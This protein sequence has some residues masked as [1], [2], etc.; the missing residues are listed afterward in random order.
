MLTLC[1]VVNSSWHLG[2]AWGSS[3]LK[4]E[5]FI[6]KMEA[7]HWVGNDALWVVTVTVNL[8]ERRCHVER[9]RLLSRLPICRHICTANYVMLTAMSQVWWKSEKVWTVGA[10][11]SF[12]VLRR[13]YLS[14]NITTSVWDVYVACGC[15]QC[16]LCAVS[17]QG[18][19]TVGELCSVEED[20]YKIC[21]EFHNLWTMLRIIRV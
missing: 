5:S 11:C 21:S 2:W 20:F 4:K 14:Q 3:C 18:R 17:N 12:S 6:L 1:H 15:R 10:H 7:V 19:V 13:I 16:L 9:G 8:S